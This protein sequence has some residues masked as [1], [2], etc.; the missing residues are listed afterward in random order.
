MTQ[1]I[2][3]I[4]LDDRVNTLHA[5]FAERVK[6]S[7]GK[8]AFTHYEKSQHQWCSYTWNDMDQRISQWQ[9]ALARS[10]LGSN[11]K[12][13]IMMRN[14]PEWVIFEQAGLRTGAVIVPLYP[15][16]RP[17]NLAH[18][19]NQAEV[20]VVLLE[21]QAQYDALMLACEHFDHKP[22]I[23]CLDHIKGKDSL[24]LTWVNTWLAA[25]ENDEPPVVH[26]SHADDLATI[27]YTSGTTGLPKGVMLSHQNILFNARS[28]VSAQM[29]FTT[30][31]FLSF[32]PL[33]HTLE[34]TVGLYIPVLAGA[35]IAFCRSI[36]QLAEDLQIIRP[37]VIISVPRIFEKVYTKISTQLEDKSPLARKL[38]HA[39]VQV[40]WQKFEVDQGRASASL[41]IYT[42]PLLKK[43]V[44]DKVMEKLGGRMRFAIC[45]GA[46]LTETIAQTFIG[47]GLPVLQGYGLTECSPVISVNI[48][49]DNRP[50]SIGKPLNGVEVRLAD[51][52][53]LE[54]RS[55]CVMLGYWKN[56]NATKECITEDGW[57]KTGDLATIEDNY[58][59]ITGRKKEILVLSNGEK[60]PPADVEMAITLDPLFEQAMVIG[61]Q[62]PFLT[63]VVVLSQEGWEKF[64]KQL[65]VPSEESSLQKREVKAAVLERIAKCMHQFPGYAQVRGVHLSLQTW[66]DENGLLTASLKMRRGPLMEHY[67]DAIEAM[68][69]K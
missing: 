23:V 29:V 62:R 33:S 26:N 31:L 13:A 6:R 8:T 35:T 14:C 3:D 40:G 60:I 49:E 65:G 56:E 63:A 32:L 20:K 46:P 10:G 45:G 12:I 17:D 21:G 48:M 7:P 15:N 58:I 37:T 1:E 61:E 16:D 64:S 53:E 5:L 22:M 52:S 57:L 51:D 24:P 30:D 2:N 38:F 41:S 44:A 55:P 34:R 4:I 47:L 19:I 18:I 42:W 54:T 50:A 28:G 69:H 27:V 9:K 39:A 68:Y 66:S 43:L 11:D 36:P 25:A 67:A 59:Y